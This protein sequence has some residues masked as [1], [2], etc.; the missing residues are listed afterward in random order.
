MPIR[1]WGNDAEDD[2][3]GTWDVVFLGGQQMPGVATVRLKLPTGIHK[4]KARGKRGAG[5]KDEGAEPRE[6]LIELTLDT[7]SDRE[8]A[9][10]ARDFIIGQT[11]AAAQDPLSIEHESANYFG[12]NTVILGNVDI[13]APDPV[14]G[15]KWSIQAFEWIAEE[16][17]A[18]VKDQKKR[19][20]DDTAAWLPYRDD[21]TAGGIALPSDDDAAHGNLPDP[22]AP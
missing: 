16:N 21:G 14:D 3:R 22:R 18:T 17:M 12:I 2:D 13:D 7:A 1:N 8:L 10:Q 11:F 6:V 4:R 15:W 20:T 19:P 5:L 9:D